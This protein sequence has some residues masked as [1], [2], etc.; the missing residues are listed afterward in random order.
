MRQK[1][2][3]RRRRRRRRRFQAVWTLKWKGKQQQELL[4]LFSACQFTQFNLPRANNPARPSTS[5]ISRRASSM[6]VVLGVRKSCDASIVPTMRSSL[7]PQHTNSSAYIKNN[8]TSSPVSTFSRP[9]TPTCAK[10]G[11][12]TPSQQQQ[13][14]HQEESSSAIQQDKEL[15]LETAIQN[16]LTVSQHKAKPRS[17]SLIWRPSRKTKTQPETSD[18]RVS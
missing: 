2:E 15:N 18:C 8:S 14:Q 13:Q 4:E 1:P 12:T 6:K 5:D 7:T 16:K 9:Q 11:R 3:A 17:R 10:P